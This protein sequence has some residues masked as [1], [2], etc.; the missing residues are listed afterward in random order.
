MK[1]YFNISVDSS[2]FSHFDI[3]ELISGNIAFDDDAEALAIAATKEALR[4]NVGHNLEV[5]AR[6][7]LEKLEE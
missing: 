7:I 4:E 5:F 2:N 6:T 1:A 3:A